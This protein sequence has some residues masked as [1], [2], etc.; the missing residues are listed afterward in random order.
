MLGFSFK[1]VCWI[2]ILR[3]LYRIAATLAPVA[4]LDHVLC[5]APAIVLDDVAPGGGLLAVE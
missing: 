5:A 3:L 2:A 1:R 4:M